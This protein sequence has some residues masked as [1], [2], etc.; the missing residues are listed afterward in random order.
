MQGTLFYCGDDWEVRQVAQGYC[1]VFILGDI[2]KLPADDPWKT[3]LHDRI[4]ARVLNKMS[5]RGT[6][7]PQPF[8]NSV[9]LRII[10]LHLYSRDE[11]QIHVLLQEWLWKDSLLLLMRGIYYIEHFEWRLILQKNMPAYITITAIVVENANPIESFQLKKNCSRK[12]V[13]HGFSCFLVTR[14]LPWLTD[15]KYHNKNKNSPV[16]FI[17]RE[18]GL[19]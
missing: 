12:L 13:L 11:H 17:P 2:Q 4:W 5:S 14:T 16:C 19:V 7:P 9:I 15:Q 8:C 1:G 10:Q 6:F 3:A 18:F